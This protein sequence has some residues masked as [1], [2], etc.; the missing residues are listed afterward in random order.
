MLGRIETYFQPQE[1]AL[2]L[3][4]YRQEVLASNIANADTPNYKARDFDFGMAYRQARDVQQG[5]GALRN[6]DARHLQPAGSANPLMPELGYRTPH[7]PSIDGNTVDMTTEMSEFSQNAIRYQAAVMFF[8]RR[9]E[10]M[11]TALTGQ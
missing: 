4:A 2:K 1:T 3:S 7:Q 9:V 6:T 10:G 5:Q 11:R 8:Q